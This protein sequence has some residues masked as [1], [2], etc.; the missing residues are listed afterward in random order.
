MIKKNFIIILLFIF[1]FLFLSYQSLK[2]F[3]D[4]PSFKDDS[5]S[6]LSNSSS[7]NEQQI[8]WEK[9]F[10]EFHHPLWND[11]L[12]FSSDKKYIKRRYH[13]DKGY[14]KKYIP[15]EKL[16]IKWDKYGE[17]TFIYNGY[18]KAYFYQDPVNLDNQKI[19]TFYQNH[20]KLKGNS[21][22]LEITENTI[23][24]QDNSGFKRF[25][26]NNQNVYEPIQASKVSF[27]QPKKIAILYIS[28]GRY[29]I[30]WENFYNSMEKHFL[31]NHDKTYFLF[32]DHDELEVP[33]NVV[34][35]H[36]DQ[37]PWPYVT[38]KRYHFFEAIK[39]KLE[40]FDYIYFLN[41]DCQPVRDINEEIFPTNEQEIMVT[42]HSWF[43]LSHK[44][45]YPY[46]RNPQSK[47]YIPYHQGR[48][49]I[50]GAFNGGTSKG[51]LKMTSIIKKWTDIDIKNNITPI[52]H[53][54]SM[55]NKYLFTYFNQNP[56]L[57][58]FPEY[59]ITQSYQYSAS[60][61]FPFYK[62]MLINKNKKGGRD[63]LR[64]L[65]EKKD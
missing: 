17:E 20:P 61:E 50:T 9:T 10:I 22:I 56:P 39:D 3:I 48:F 26:K 11:A 32:T 21:K 8:E 47:S 16:I 4:T 5:S 55:I 30:F 2:F 12:H 38:M 1:P 45:K 54:E 51:F 63:Y 52:F 57:I 13:S 60:I 64:G 44:N 53:D 34:K 23:A 37:L 62:M 36:Q 18:Q 58:L 35:I 42:L 25:K 27:T 24:I 43:W 15:D 31:P 6:I 33:Q 49:Y 29:I 41:G 46:E 19:Q 28:T 7:I 59:V 40:K 14:V 65:K